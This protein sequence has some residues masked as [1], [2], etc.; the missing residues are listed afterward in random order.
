MINGKLHPIVT[1]CR[2]DYN[3]D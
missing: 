3:N 1:D 2:S